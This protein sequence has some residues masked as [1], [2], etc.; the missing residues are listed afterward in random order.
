MQG[1]VGD[2]MEQMLILFL[3][4]HV[5]R[6]T[7]DLNTLIESTSWAYCKKTKSTILVKYSDNT[8]FRGTVNLGMGWDITV[9]MGSLNKK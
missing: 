2:N 1:I 6:W 8:R 7:T 3:Y 5:H 4:S 9:E